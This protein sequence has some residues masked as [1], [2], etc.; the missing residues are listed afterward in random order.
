MSDIETGFAVF[1]TSCNPREYAI[2]RPNTPDR[3]Y[4]NI[5]GIAV[6]PQT[7][8]SFLYKDGSGKEQP[9]S[10]L[11]CAIDKTGFTI[12]DCTDNKIIDIIYAVKV[13]DVSGTNE[14]DFN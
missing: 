14:C 4:F 9:Y 3:P 8:L 5:V 7:L 10:K 1:Y 13:Y 6:G 12:L 11:N 2:I